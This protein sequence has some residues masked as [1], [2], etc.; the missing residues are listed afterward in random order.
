LFNGWPRLNPVRDN[1]A[2]VAMV[3][4]GRADLLV[5]SREVARFHERQAGLPA[6]EMR[7]AEFLPG[8]IVPY[9]FGLRR[10][11]HDAETLIAAFDEAQAVLAA[12]GK[13]E[14]ALAHYRAPDSSS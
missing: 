14:A 9:H 13:I 3:A 2:A 8:G 5:T 12:Q 7:E 4:A 1:A 10:S 6:L 11:L